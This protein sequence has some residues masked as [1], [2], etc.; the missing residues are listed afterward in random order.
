MSAQDARSS[1]LRRQQLTLGQVLCRGA[2]RV[3]SHL[4]SL[5]G[6][7]WHAK[8]PSDILSRAAVLGV[9]WESSVRTQPFHCHGLGSLPGRATRILQAVQHGQN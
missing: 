8:L 1:A 2:G 5:Q 4:S 6:S 7:E 3:T 9:S